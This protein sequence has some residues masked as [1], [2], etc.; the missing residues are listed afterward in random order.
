MGI[1]SWNPSKDCG[2]CRVAACS[3]GAPFFWRGTSNG[4]DLTFHV[5]SWID[6]ARQWRSGILYPHW[7]A[8]ANYGSGE[9]R[10]VFYPPISWTSGALLGLVLALAGCARHVFRAGVI[11]AG[12]SMYL[13][14]REWLEDR[15]AIVAAILYAVN[16]YLLVVIYERGAFAEMIAAIWL[17]GILLFALRER[18]GF[19]AQLASARTSH[20]RRLA[21][22]PCRLRSLRVTCWRSS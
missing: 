9:P 2:G 20:G 12:V 11:A 6:V 15:T 1:R 16:P 17:P 18:G 10:F 3:R 5:D 19:A 8:F 21:H 22:E 13:F 14:A 4:H 7:A